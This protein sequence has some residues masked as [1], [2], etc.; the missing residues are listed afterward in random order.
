[1]NAQQ[2]PWTQICCEQSGLPINIY[3]LYTWHIIG[4]ATK[5]QQRLMQNIRSIQPR[6]FTWRHPPAAVAGSAIKMP[7]HRSDANSLS[8]QGKCSHS[9]H[10]ILT[11]NALHEESKYLSMLNSTESV[12]MKTR[13][14]N[15]WHGLRDICKKDFNHKWQP[16]QMIGW[17]GLIAQW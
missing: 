2:Y 13:N 1:M 5:I 11:S 16:F 9:D 10:I 8:L 12:P 4:V 15:E 3:R 17:N 6:R 7:H 14:N